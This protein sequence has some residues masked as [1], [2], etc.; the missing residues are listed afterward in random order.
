M[1]M[2]VLDFDFD[3]GFAKKKVVCLFFP[4]FFHYRYLVRW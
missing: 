3:F 2:Q 1:V 4:G